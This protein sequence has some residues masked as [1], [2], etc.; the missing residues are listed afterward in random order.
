MYLV[1]ECNIPECENKMS[2]KLLI[3]T[4]VCIFL[5][6]VIVREQ[7]ELFGLGMCESE[8]DVILEKVTLKG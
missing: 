6:S 2:L 3:I 7:N 8:E 4:L 1:T 5:Q